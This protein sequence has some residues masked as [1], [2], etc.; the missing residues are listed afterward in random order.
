MWS[1]YNIPA[2]LNLLSF[3]APLG[4]KKLPTPLNAKMNVR[5]ILAVKHLQN[6]R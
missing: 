2:F 4:A 1:L 5:D 3:M 6:E